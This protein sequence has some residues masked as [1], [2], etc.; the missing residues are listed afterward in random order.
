[1]ISP[2]S[3]RATAFA[4]A[5]LLLSAAAPAAESD[6][7]ILKLSGS[8]T[9]ERIAANARTAAPSGDEG[10]ETFTERYP[11]GNI[12]IERQV[13]LDASGNYVNHGIWKM[14]DPAGKVVAQGQFNMGRRSGVWSR[15]HE[16]NESAV[17]GQ[18]PFNRFQAPFLSQAK[19][20]EGVLDGEWTIF[21]AA[22]QKCS[23]V[24]IRNGTRHGLSVVWAPGGKVLRQTNY[25][26][27]IPVGDVLQMNTQNG[28]IERAATYIKGR[29]VISKTSHYRRGGPKK[30]EAQ[31]LA[32]QTVQIAP[33]DYWKVEFARYENEGEHLRHGPSR[34]WH[35][36]GQLQLEG[37]FDH[38]QRVGHFTYWHP[39]SQKAAEGKFVKD[40]H[41]G[42]WV[43]WHENG[44]KA[45]IGQYE[46]GALIGL[47]RWWD[48]HGKLAKQMVYDQPQTVADEEEQPSLE[49][50]KREELQDVKLRF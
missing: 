33:D 34:T 24:S 43:W 18:A 39:N 32:P 15:W 4:M 49:V 47:W 22:K 3:Q 20:T 23:L 5:G 12:K 27:G 13:T 19:F 44:Q 17:F 7:S 1:M 31:F 36:N 30:T 38:D 2:I 8:K 21:D 41:H 45:A 46:H 29:Q 6:S 35:A 25:S 48:E 50:G 11:K 9:V 42:A 40:K 28:E 26:S 37:Q 14:Y 10:V 16:R